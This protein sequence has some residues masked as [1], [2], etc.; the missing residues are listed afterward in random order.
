MW[1]TSGEDCAVIQMQADGGWDQSGDCEGRE[2]RTDTGCIL[3]AEVAEF[4]AV[5]FEGKRRVEDNTR[6]F[7]PGNA[8]A[9]NG[10]G[11]GCGWHE[12]R[13]RGGTDQQLRLGHAELEVPT[14]PSGSGGDGWSGGRACG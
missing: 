12:F 13:A 5:G 14:A 10:E 3:K 7:D 1:K 2:K 9:I 6:V 4:P 8:A 11:K